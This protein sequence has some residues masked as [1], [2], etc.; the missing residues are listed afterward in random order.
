MN[1]ESI[2]MDEA[3]Q[4]LN[5]LEKHLP[6]REEVIYLFGSFLAGRLNDRLVPAGF[7]IACE[8]A[9][10]DLQKGT[11]GFT[12][13]PIQNNLVGYPPTIYALLRMEIPNITETI[14]PPAFATAVK[15]TIKEINAR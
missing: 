15:K 5:E 12:G 11:D 14:F 3:K 2:S 9:L 10:Y 1:T 6:R 13:K 7:V 8:L 4:K